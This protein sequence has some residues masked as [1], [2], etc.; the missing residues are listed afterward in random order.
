MFKSAQEKTM[1]LTRIES[2]NLLSNKMIVF[3]GIIMSGLQFVYNRSLWSDE[4]ML[5]VNILNRDFTGLLA[6]L[7]YRQS[8]PLLFLYV[9]KLFSI[10]IPGEMGLRIFPLLCFLGS[11]IFFGKTV[12]LVFK[13]SSTIAFCISAFTFNYML[14]MY[15]SEVK[16]YMADV[17]IS[18]MFIFFLLND[19][20][21]AK[22]GPKLLLIAGV[23]ASL[24]SNISPMILSTFWLFIVFKNKGDLNK[25]IKISLI[26]LSWAVIFICY[27]L[28]YASSESLKDFMQ[29]YWSQKEPAFMPLNPFSLEFWDFFYSKQ[30]MVFRYLFKFG[31]VAAFCF[32]LLFIIGL[33]FMIIRKQIGLLIICIVP[34]IIHLGMSALM[35]YPFHIRFCLYLIPGIILIMATGFQNIIDKASPNLK[36][37]WFPSAIFPTLFFVLFMNFQLSGFPLTKQEFRSAFKYVSENLQPVDKIIVLIGNRLDVEYYT[38]TGIVKVPESRFIRLES[39]EES[40]IERN[41]EL[42]ESPIWLIDNFSTKLYCDKARKILE[43]RNWILSNEI[44]KNGAS[45]SYY[46][47][48]PDK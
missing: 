17:L 42:I 12:K 23:V 25:I 29:I 13:S 7:D 14:I 41:L 44:I 30:L 6:T 11:L 36:F 19:T 9:E 28:L 18:S 45:A 31:A 21:N 10:I 16:Q 39:N 4:S 48:G 3:A 38:M 37:A 27:Y 8:A 32:K 35:L 46:I 5:A 20:F 34:I 26:G 1:I 47:P 22:R 2:F 15:S 24:M 43:S 33:A 40:L